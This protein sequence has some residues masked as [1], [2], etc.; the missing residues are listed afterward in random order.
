MAFPKSGRA[1][2]FR[3]SGPLCG[4]NQRKASFLLSSS[5]S[6]PDRTIEQRQ[7]DAEVAKQQASNSDG[8]QRYGDMEDRAPTS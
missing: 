4:T 3:P 1:I 6:G 2:F 7:P 8:K 5:A